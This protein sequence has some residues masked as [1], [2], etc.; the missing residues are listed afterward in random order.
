MRPSLQHCCCCCAQPRTRGGLALMRRRAPARRDGLRCVLGECGCACCT[1]LQRGLRAWWQSTRQRRQR[2]G[3]VA[4]AAGGAGR[5]CAYYVAR[6]L[7]GLG[8]APTSSSCV[9]MCTTMCTLHRSWTRAPAST[10]ITTSCPK[11]TALQWLPPLPLQ[12]LPL[13][14]WR[15]QQQTIVE[16]GAVCKQGVCVSRTKPCGSITCL[17]EAR[18]P[19][20]NRTHTH[21]R[22][23]QQAP[24][25]ITHSR[26]RPPEEEGGGA[27]G[28]FWRG[29]LL[30]R[31]HNRLERAHQVRP[32]HSG[33]HPSAQLPAEAHCRSVVVGGKQS[34]QTGLVLTGLVCGNS[35]RS[36]GMFFQ[37][38]E[39]PVI[40]GAGCVPTAP[41]HVALR[42]HAVRQLVTPA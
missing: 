25:C 38:A 33:V 24:A 21:Q 12:P 10:C 4:R 9:T 32:R 7:A 11:V 14:Q 13:Q 36:S 23:Q 6:G 2:Q 20:V 29:R 35:A 19:V 28:A 16:M 18:A 41:L 34:L 26:V 42:R 40:E 3:A 1:P 39:D 15:H 27:A 31:L 17:S 5:A 22:T 8:M 30:N 37:R